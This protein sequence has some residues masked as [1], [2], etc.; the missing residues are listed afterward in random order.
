VES[1]HVLVG[2]SYAH[3]RDGHESTRQLLFR[4]CPML[5]TSEIR[6]RKEDVGI[7]DDRFLTFRTHKLGCEITWNPLPTVP[8]QDLNLK[9]PGSRFRVAL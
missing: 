1:V 2:D 8:T 6:I 4:E 3:G 7:G 5:K 9:R